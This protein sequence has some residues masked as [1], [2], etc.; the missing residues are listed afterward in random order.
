[1]HWFLRVVEG[2]KAS[3]YYFKLKRD[4]TRLLGFSAL[5]KCTA[6][7]RM[8]AFGL[9]VDVIPDEESTCLESMHIMFQTILFFRIHW[10]YR[11]VNTVS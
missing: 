10:F 11:N 6:T 8:I 3:D 9:F 1:M 7:M 2:V 4:C 5:Q